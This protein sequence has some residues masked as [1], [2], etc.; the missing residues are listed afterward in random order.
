[1]AEFLDTHFIG[2]GQVYRAFYS[3]C[4]CE[5]RFEPTTLGGRIV[6]LGL[7]F[8]LMLGAMALRVTVNANGPKGEP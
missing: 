5:S 7:A 4:M 6:G 1:M 2:S 3:L 8:L